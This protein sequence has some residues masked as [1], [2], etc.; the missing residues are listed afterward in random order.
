METIVKDFE[1]RTDDSV[2]D[3]I[4][5]LGDTAKLI[6]PTLKDCSGVKADW[7]KLTKMINICS[8][9]YSFAYHVGKDL[10]VNGVDIFKHVYDSVKQYRAGE[11]EPFGEDLGYAFAKLLIG[12]EP[13][14]VNLTHLKATEENMFIY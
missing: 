5:K 3:G 13:E 14:Q 2:K 12:E 11:W 4:K 8:N 7:T 6:Q 10:L 1:L 9:P